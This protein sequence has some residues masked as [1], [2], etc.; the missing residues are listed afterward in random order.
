MTDPAVGSSPSPTINALPL[1]GEI[2]YDPRP[3]RE[4]MRGY[5]A[6]ALL[7]L[8]FVIVLLAFILLF[9]G[10]A[11][12]AGELVNQFFAPVVALAGTAVGFYFGGKSTE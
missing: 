11:A 3:H 10:D 2:P 6:L 8:L 9:R 7:A 4:S 1:I 5:V 12:S